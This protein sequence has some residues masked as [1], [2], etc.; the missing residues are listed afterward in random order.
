MIYFFIR[1]FLTFVFKGLCMYKKLLFSLFAL[2][3]SHSA[4]AS[5]YIMGDS[6]AQ[7]IAQNLKVCA[8]ATKVGLN[9]DNAAVYW[10]NNLG[11]S[12]KDVVII[13][14][15]VNDGNN[16]T[17]ENL[18]KIREKINSPYIIWILPS[19]KDKAGIVKT[20]A[21]HYNDYVLDIGSVIGKD[22]IHPTIKGYQAIAENIKN[23]D[24]K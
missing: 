10:L 2:I 11:F 16:P 19:K 21:K 3:L 9:T 20:I 15:G 8:S 7:G 23:F 24:F 18:V 5:C 17:L 13:S 4:F 6:I 22:G 1:V 12:G 14:L